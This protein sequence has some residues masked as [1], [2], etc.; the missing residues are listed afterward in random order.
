MRPVR[1]S[2]IVFDPIT[3]KPT[4]RDLLPPDYILY[5]KLRARM[6]SGQL[7]K[8]QILDMLGKDKRLDGLDAADKDVIAGAVSARRDDVGKNGKTLGDIVR[9][10]VERYLADKGNAPK[11]ALQMDAE[12][13]VRILELHF[14]NMFEHRY[15]EFEPAVAESKKATEAEVL[16]AIGAIPGSRLHEFAPSGITIIELLVQIMDYTIY[17]SVRK[18]V[19][20]KLK[21]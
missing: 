19:H 3:G 6:I 20:E 8:R 17:D 7:R 2:Q 5:P 11:I 4:Y 12:A 16:A 18:A 15:P 21:N 13:G 9:E 14:D 1:N 10:E